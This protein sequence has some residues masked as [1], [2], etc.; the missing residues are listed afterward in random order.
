MIGLSA[1]ACL[2][3]IVF[4]SAA[5]SHATSSS[6][7]QV[8]V[9]A[10]AGATPAG[11]HSLPLDACKSPV[12]APSDLVVN[13]PAPDATPDAA[14]FAGSWGGIWDWPTGKLVAR[15][16][17]TDVHA[18]KVSFIY[19]WGSNPGATPGFS[20]VNDATVEGNKI[21]FGNFKM[22]YSFAVNPERNSIAAQLDA[23]DTLNMTMTR[24]P[25]TG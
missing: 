22:L 18:D 1:A 5:C 9:A 21:Q 12:G 7:A 2:L 3:V 16:I 15:L 8:P 13:A 6:P 25:A 20:R 19:A 11:Q 10:A 23:R 24:C 14:A 17:V 4:S